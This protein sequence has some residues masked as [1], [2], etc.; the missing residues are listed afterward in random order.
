[1]DLCGRGGR[2]ADEIISEE[3]RP[4]FASHHFRRLATHVVQVLLDRANIEFRVPVES[5]SLGDI[6]LHIDGRVGQ[7]G[8]DRDLRRTIDGTLVGGATSLQSASGCPNNPSVKFRR[9]RYKRRDH[10]PKTAADR[11]RG[12]WSRRHRETLLGFDRQRSPRRAES[13][14]AQGR[15][16][17]QITS[18]PAETQESRARLRSTSA[19][20]TIRQCHSGLVPDQAI[21]NARG[22]AAW[23]AACALSNR[24]QPWPHPATHVSRCS[25][26]VHRSL[27]ASQCCAGG[28]SADAQPFHSDQPANPAR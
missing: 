24:P 16:S 2:R 25:A 5:V 17:H 11:M 23:L 4:Q 9:A 26:P 15:Q 14:L 6:G 22:R 27:G 12:T 13:V 7:C 1:M 18:P 3:R 28:D 8:G 20:F 21:Q 10:P 19:H